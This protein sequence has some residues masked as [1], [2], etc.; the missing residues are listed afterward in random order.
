MEDGAGGFSPMEAGLGEAQAQPD[1]GTLIDR[2][3]AR[4]LIRKAA[5]GREF[6][7]FLA[8]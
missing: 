3:T 4:G 2:P 5:G 6:A 7:F 1:G 8:R